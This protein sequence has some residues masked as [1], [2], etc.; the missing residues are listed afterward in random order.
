MLREGCRVI[1]S[2]TVQTGCSGIADDILEHRRLM[3]I[4]L[5]EVDC[6]GIT[7]PQVF[8]FPASPHF[9]RLSGR[10]CG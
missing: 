9:C 3:G 6:L 7:C 8:P 10:K 1:T 5:Q 2:K 4:P